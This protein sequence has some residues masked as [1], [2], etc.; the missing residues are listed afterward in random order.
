MN[1]KKHAALA[2][3]LI[4]ACDGLADAAREAGV[5]KALLSTY[6]NPNEAATMPARIIAV[7]EEYCGEGIYS[8]A[9][10]TRSHGIM[11]SDDVIGD[12]LKLD[13]AATLFAC[14]YHHAIHG[15]QT[16]GRIDAQEQRNLDEIITRVR[17]LLD[18][19]EA[20]VSK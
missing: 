9:L 5:S 20:G 4:S 8:R 2:R 11:P 15:P 6:Q 19:L 12:A 18:R 10:A 17:S 7:L 3:S 13:Q 16:P 1:A 14:T